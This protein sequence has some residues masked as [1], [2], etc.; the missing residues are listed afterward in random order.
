MS[1]HTTI[2]LEK[3]TFS[4]DGNDILD[5]VSF[6]VPAGKITTLLG[7]SGS[8]KTSV[9]RLLNR[10]D[11]PTLGRIL[12]GGEDIRE[13][14]VQ[15]LRRRVGMVFQVP[16]M[17]E[18]TVEKNLKTAKGFCD[19]TQCMRIEGLLSLVELPESYLGRNAENLSV[20]EQQRVQLA[21]AL[22]GQ[23]EVLL[24]D[25]PTSGLDVNTA[26]RILD[27]IQRINRETGK[28]ILFV[29]HL[30]DQARRLA[31]RVVLIV[32]GSI[33]RQQP[34]REFFKGSLDDVRRLFDGGSHDP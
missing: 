11:D 12:L 24:L 32:E 30:L 22:I 28:T 5:D 14:D 34:A 21:R 6:S 18:G 20:G 31:E 4:R 1:H 26:E 19:E 10:L 25:E 29:T 15:E 23:P 9:L 16:V 33:R 17:F 2:R 13:L 8:G 7:P 27:L 3:V